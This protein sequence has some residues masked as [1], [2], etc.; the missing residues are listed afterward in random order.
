[1]RLGAATVGLLLVSAAAH[2]GALDE[3]AP[4]SVQVSPREAFALHLVLNQQQ[5]KGEDQD[6]EARVSEALGFPAID[7]RIRAIK[8]DERREAN[9][10]DFSDKPTPRTVPRDDLGRVIAWLKDASLPGIFNEILNPLVR[11]IRAAVAKT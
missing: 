7:A 4:V 11:R 2:A 9:G 6:A 3:R 1:M 5:F 8:H 10:D